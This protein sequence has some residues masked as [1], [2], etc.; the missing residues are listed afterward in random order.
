[1][2]IMGGTFP[3][4]DNCDIPETLGQHNL[5]L[6]ENV[7]GTQSRWYEFLP[8]LEIVKVPEVITALIGGTYVYLRLI[9][10]IY[11]L[12]HMIDHLEVLTSQRL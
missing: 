1:M 10:S 4:S 11:F 5:N 9:C 12:T 2:I 7:P 3:S 8:D 6:G